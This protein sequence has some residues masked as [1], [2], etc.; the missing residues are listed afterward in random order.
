[1]A[2]SKEAYQ[3]LEDIVG[4]ENISQESAT[5]DSY[6]WS[7]SNYERAPDRSGF[8]AIR[9][10]AVLLPG[11]TEEVQ[12]I[13]KTCNRCRI[14]FR[15]SSSGWSGFGA[16]TEGVINLDLRR[17]NRILEI[18]EKNM[19]AVVEPYVICAQ[20]Q[21]EAMKVGLNC[22]ITGAGG[23]CSPLASATS[24][25]GHGADSLFIG[26]S[27]EVL[28]AFEWVMPNGDIMRSGSL[29]SGLGWFCSEGPGPSLRGIIRGKS[30]VGGAMGVFT[31]CALKLSPWPGPPVMTIEG[32]VPAYN[33]PLPDNI[34]TYTVVLP[35]WQAYADAYY[36]IFDAEIGIIA[37]RQFN[38]LGEDLWPAFYTMYNDPTKSLDDLE[39]F[40][41]KPEIQKLTDEVRH[42]NFHII[43]GGMTPRDI[44]YQEKVLDRILA[45]T[46]GHRVAAMSE[47]TMERFTALY[48]LKLAFKNLNYVYGGYR[49][50]SFNQQGTP[51]FCVSYAPVAVELLRKYQEKGALVKCGG[52]CLLGKVGGESGGG[53]TANLEQFGWYNI[54]DIESR[55]TAREY[56]EAAAKAGR[57]MGIGG[58]MAGRPTVFAAEPQPARFHWQWKI[59]QMLD[60]NDAGES[61][62][63]PTLEKLPK[64]EG[65]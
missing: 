5:L 46:G 50:A 19:F 39:G 8:A 63:Y 29:G 60:P 56:H 14:K 23:S 15:A 54:D 7:Q 42:Y 20:L 61:K 11:S 53:G 45:D 12:A 41:K 24:G 25:G 17:M 36:K 43:L 62:N 31:R 38:S 22:H 64:D 10:E 55:K 26:N 44:E 52:D 34:R 58:G 18:D 21:A 16:P 57:E 6:N 40:V 49:L 28:L 59:K 3:A 37:D 32:T 48:L 13:V 4:P 33:T 51:D 35:S 2:L 9:P 1:M 27:P 30:G 47:P 65:L